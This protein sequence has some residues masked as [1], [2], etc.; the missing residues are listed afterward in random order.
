MVTDAAWTDM[1]DDKSM[2]L[3]VVG[4]WM[5]VTILLNQNGKLENKT[6]DY[7]GGSYSGWWN[8]LLIGDFN[9]DGKPDLIVGNQG[10]NTQCKVSNE[11][12]AE[13]YYKDFDENGSVDPILCFYIKD[14]SYPY[15]FRDELLDQMSN[16]RTRFADYK[17]YADVTLKD[18]F[19]KEELN[20]AGHLKA[21]H[22]K[23]SYFESTS[24]GKLH[25]KELP[26][27]VQYAPVFTI[28]SL[29]YNDDGKD[30]LL[31]CGNIN[32]ARLRFGKY[33]ANYGVLLKGD[34]KGNFSY[35]DQQQSGFNLRGDV[36][37][38]LRLND[39]ILFGINGSE[40]KTYRQKKNE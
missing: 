35:I 7:L 22:L 36:R 26:L 40:T 14:T 3:V 25:E 10:L 9:G 31:F 27:A 17:S 6:S 24:D 30:D 23:T 4:E 21:N 29:D 1:N 18:I 32:R 12:P 39:M 19:T 20:N 38:V 34:G 8:K 33:D 15:V 2:D 13:M 16:M 5:P 11:Q 28:T 37:S